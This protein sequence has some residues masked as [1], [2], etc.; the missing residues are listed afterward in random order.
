[1]GFDEIELMTCIDGC[2][3]SASDAERAYG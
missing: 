2:S 3:A 1:M